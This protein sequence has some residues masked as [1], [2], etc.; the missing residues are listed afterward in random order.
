MVVWTEIIGHLDA[1][2]ITYAAVVGTEA[3]SPWTP[4]KSGR[5]K[6]LQVLICAEAA[7]SLTNGVV[8]RLTCTTFNPNTIKV[9]GEGGGLRTAPFT[10]NRPVIYKCDQQV[11]A[12]VPVIVEARNVAGSPV[13]VNALL[14]ATIEG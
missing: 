13:T 10:A 1:E 14:L 4:T 6:E 5:I 2:G 3:P 11:T 7:T 12:G 8:F 9:A